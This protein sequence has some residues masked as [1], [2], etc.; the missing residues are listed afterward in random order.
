VLDDH[1]GIDVN[2]D[3]NEAPAP[4]PFVA[5]EPEAP[6]RRRRAPAKKASAG[7]YVVAEGKAV[8]TKRGT[9]RGGQTVSV[10][11]FAGGQA[12]LDTL[13]SKGAVVES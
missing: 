8:T 2:E 12:T 6:K 11:D 9:R 13:V 7:G 5:E 3:V 1:A 10:R 4:E